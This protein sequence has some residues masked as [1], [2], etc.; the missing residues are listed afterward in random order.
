MSPGK[1]FVLGL[2]C[3][4]LTTAS[5]AAAQ[6]ELTVFADGIL[7]ELETVSRKGL[8]ELPLPAQIREGTLRV[9]P[10]DGGTVH[11]VKLLPA[12]ATERQQKERDALVEQR[13]R[14]QDRMKALQ[15]REGIF[16]A[17]A[18]SQ[19]S[20]APRKSKTNPDP[21]AS[22]R[23][24]T[25]FAIAQLESVYTARRRTEQELKRINE[26]LAALDTKRATGPTLRV[27]V[28]PANARI[29]I[30]SVLKEGGWI[31]RY[32]IRLQ[33]NAT[34]QLVLN[35]EI[36]ALPEGFTV[37]VVPAEMSAGLP[38]NSYPVPSAGSFARLAT[39]Q[40]PV[41]K[42]QITVVPMPAFSFGIK[43]ISGSML[44]VG[45]AD[46]YLNGEYLG[47]AAFPATAAGAVATVSS[48]R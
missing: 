33:G 21:L 7:M 9:K 27:T 40:L 25:E 34:A 13:N 1:L 37:K 47:V 23:Q 20:K 38:Q 41:E 18:K 15:H 17:A 16:S 2:L 28:S 42:E 29:R 11:Q 31:P 3:L 36:S 5:A 6:R 24:G 46:I 12:K 26:K 48:V 4:V 43:N 32:E 22:V 30:A 44:Q 39:W 10:L 14:L 8:A 19:S 35:A 45:T